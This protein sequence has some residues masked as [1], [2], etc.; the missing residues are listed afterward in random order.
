[1]ASYRRQLLGE[2]LEMSE[3]SSILE[4]SSLSLRDDDADNGG[5]AALIGSK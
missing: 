2:L 1:M 4:M 5:A 3:D